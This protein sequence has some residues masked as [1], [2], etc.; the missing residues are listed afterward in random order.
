MNQFVER[1][2]LKSISQLILSVLLHPLLIP[3][4]G[5][6]V[7]LNAGDYDM[8]PFEYKHRFIIVVFGITAL[9]P[10]VVIYLLKLIGICQS[11]QMQTRAERR[12]PLLIV[13]IATYS[14]RIMSAY[15]ITLISDFMM[16][17]TIIITI[18]IFIN[19]L[20]KISLHAL[21]WGG[22]TALIAMMNLRYFGELNVMLIITILTSGL[23]MTCRLS[24][25]EHTP[26]QVYTGFTIGL[27]VSSIG[28][29]ISLFAI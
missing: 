20:W 11:L 27:I 4:L 18:A 3:T 25:Q 19:M 17:T 15:S 28:C 5:V 12:I 24:M 16:I 23:I 21:A 26:A 14:M 6:C 29:I 9:I 1:I 13:A 7:I 8:L 22:F 10:M 2:N